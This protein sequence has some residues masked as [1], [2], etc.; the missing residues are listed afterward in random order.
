MRP[1][2]EGWRSVRS[3]LARHARV[4]SGPAASPPP[5]AVSANPPSAPTATP[6]AS[7]AVEAYPSSPLRGVRWTI[8]FVAFLG[9]TLAVTSYRFPIAEVSV[10]AGLLGV[11]LVRDKMRFPRVI[12]VLGGYLLWASLGYTQ[13][14]FP[15]LV[16]DK[17]LNLARVWL[18]I[19]LAANA[20]RSRA[21]VRFFLIFL[22]GCYALF[23]VRGTF[24]NY[25]IYHE[26]LFGRAKWNQ[27]FANPNDLAAL[28]LLQLSL[29]VGLAIT[30]PKGWTQWCAAH[31]VAVLPPLM[32][33]TQSRGALI[34][35]AV[36]IVIGL[37]SQRRR[38]RRIVGARGIGRVRL[39]LAVAAVVVV[40]A[41]PKAVWERMSGLRYATSAETL[42]EVDPEQ[43][44]RQRFEIWKVATAI[45]IDH[46]VVG[47][48]LG[49][50]PLV[51]VQYARRDMFKPIGRGLRDAHSLYFTVAAETGIPGL[52]L[53]M[54]M[55]A[56]SFAH[57]DRIRRKCRR[58][59]PRASLQLFFLELGLGTFL[60]AA[61][62]S[63]LG[64][65]AFTFLH[66]IIMYVVAEAH[67]HELRRVQAG[68]SP[69]AAPPAAPGRRA[70]RRLA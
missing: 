47:V 56:L 29:A 13:T 15:E 59:L 20:V 4:S 22:L 45:A 33:F 32:L 67:A 19:L 7:D 51:H 50:Y 46:P 26:T 14:Q 21:Q 10:L 66:L 36:F 30:E 43:S 12:L 53:F 25:F 42:A 60:I 9:Y 34:A 17:L 65:L 44:A 62:W 11:L 24:A 18:I 38:L 49:A 2:L 69:A 41:A 54:V 52:T 5:G 64:H 39:G 23:P 57:A 35:L 63:S 68:Y 6:L 1:R 8:P 55:I 16:G 48:G 3:R 37:V 61:I 40:I 31:G 27:V 58:L 70:R 28:T